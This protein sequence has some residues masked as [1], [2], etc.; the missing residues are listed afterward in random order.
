VLLVL[1]MS[2]KPSKNFMFIEC[3]PFDGVHVPKDAQSSV[4]R[5]HIVREWHRQSR[6]KRLAALKAHNESSGIFKI[7][8]FETGAQHTAAQS[9]TK[10]GLLESTRLTN[11]RIE[12]DEGHSN[13]IMLRKNKLLGPLGAFELDPLQVYPLSSS[14]PLYVD[15]LIEYG[16]PRF[17][18][19]VKQVSKTD[20]SGAS[21][22]VYLA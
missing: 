6:A 5:S 14:L 20:G 22:R 10:Q 9:V 1:T 11:L 15:G 7:S 12:N 16:A 8:S 21:S 2:S 17:Q 18:Y 19:L 4:K 3:N 13:A